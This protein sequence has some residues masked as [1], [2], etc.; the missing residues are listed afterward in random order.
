MNDTTNIPEDS[1]ANASPEEIMSALFANMVIQQTNMAMM[2]LGKVAHPQTGEFVQDVEAAKMFI[3]QLE[4]L[5]HKTKGNLSKQEEGLLK[6]ALTALRMAFVE[7][8]EAGGEPQTTNQ[9]GSP[10]AD[11]GAHPE[12]IVTP[13]ASAA[14]PATAAPKA[15]PSPAAPSTDESRKK[16]SKKY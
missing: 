7:A 11:T 12:P 9:Q 10:L 1:L 15:E 2:L 3:D 8:I 16:F 5:E 6:Q 13:G 14:T 4:M